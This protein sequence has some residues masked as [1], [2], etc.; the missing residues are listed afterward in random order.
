MLT[1]ELLRYGYVLLFFAAA[2]EG[3]ASLLTATFLA[4]RGYFNLPAVI[5]TAAVAT[6]CANQAYYWLGRRHAR[7]AL[8]R[9]HTHRWFGWLRRA[10]ARHSPLLLFVSR[11]LYGLRIAVPLGCGAGGMHPV[12]FAALDLAGAALWATV[13]GLAGWA[14][15]HGL[16]ALAG[17]IRR[18]EGAIALALLLVTFAL[19]AIRGRD[20]KGAVVAERLL[21]THE[22][23]DSEGGAGQSDESSNG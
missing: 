9:L 22:Q 20:W 15:G 6:C 18:H 7:S 4:H 11:F 12:E 3:D 14:I 19:L 21:V 10:L 1:T 8:D 16:E 5:A 2:F 13:V 23:G 17:D